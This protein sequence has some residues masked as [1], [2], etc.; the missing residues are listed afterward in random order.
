ME[1]RVQ[2]LTA[3]SVADFWR[4]HGA[5]CGSDWCWCSA[6]W[7][8]T[9]RGWSDRTSADNR[10]V[11]S[12][13]FE[14]GQYD[15][16][17]LY[18]ADEPVAWCQA[19]PAHRLPKLVRQFELTVDEHTW[20]VTCFLVVRHRRREGLA[21]HLLRGVLED[22][23]H[24]GA[25]QVLGFPRPGTDQD[26]DLWNGPPRLFVQCGFE[27]VSERVARLIIAE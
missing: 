9:W 27:P 3:D 15:G 10:A 20:A 1:L 4:L 13:L 18:D 6:W 2:A 17:L 23:P 25:R 5:G 22:L 7:V 12:A 26:A 14:R 24:R 8:D 21:R 16:Y 11:R 19:G